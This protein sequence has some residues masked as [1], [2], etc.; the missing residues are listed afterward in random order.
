MRLAPAGVSVEL[1]Y[2]DMDLDVVG[3]PKVCRRGGCPN[4]AAP[5]LPAGDEG[6]CATCV[7]D[8]RK[9]RDAAA[10]DEL[11]GGSCP[12]MS[13]PDLRFSVEPIIELVRERYGSLN[14]SV[15][16]RQLQRIRQDGGLSWIQADRWARRFGKTPF[17]LWP[18]WD[19]LTADVQLRVCGDCSRELP[20]KSH[21]RCGACDSRVRRAEA[22]TAKQVA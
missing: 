5:G 13:F 1:A 8:A 12:D 7:G 20:I 6:L 14:S 2:H 3:R 22:R 10:A 16:K 21:G 4:V 9:A 19:R 11:T 15:V 17:E 18:D